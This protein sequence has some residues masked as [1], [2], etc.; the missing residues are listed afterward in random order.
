MRTVTYQGAICGGDGNYGIVFMDFPGCAS[1]GDTLDEVVRMGHEALQLHV[2][3]II[4]DG[5]PL[6]IERPHTLADVAVWLDDPDD[7]IEATWVMLAPVSVVIPRRDD[8][9]QVDVPRALADELLDLDVS[10]GNFIVDATRRELA[11]L[12]QIA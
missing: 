12:K 2:E 5:D 3:G 10:V 8:Y 6:P 11:R 1:A 9:V 7:P 4:E